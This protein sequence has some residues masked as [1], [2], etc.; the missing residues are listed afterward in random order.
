MWGASFF[1]PLCFV[2]V[3]WVLFLALFLH[4]F[5]KVYHPGLI[6]DVKVVTLYAGDPSHPRD[7]RPSL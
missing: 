2:V 3:L 4:G 7:G 1:K 6:A 5:P